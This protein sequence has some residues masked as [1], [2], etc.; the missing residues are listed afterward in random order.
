MTYTKNNSIGEAVFFCQ[1]NFKQYIRQYTYC[2]LLLII[3]NRA[4]FSSSEDDFC[5]HLWMLITVITITSVF[6]FLQRYIWLNWPG[7]RLNIE[8]ALQ[9]L[10]GLHVHSAQLYSLAETQQP[11]PPFLP[12]LGSYIK[13]R[14]W[15][16]KIDD[17]SLWRPGPAIVVSFSSWRCFGPEQ[18]TS[19]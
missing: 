6:Y 7:L 8:L 1:T 2:T 4:L 15:S 10:F 18:P 16:A 11:P 17:I 5:F 3:N 19:N 14:Y 9:S 12:H 13:G